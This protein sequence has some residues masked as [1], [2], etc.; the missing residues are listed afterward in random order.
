MLFQVE[1][2]W[3]EKSPDRALSRDY[4]CHELSENIGDDSQ[5]DDRDIN[6]LRFEVEDFLKDSSK[7]RE[8]DTYE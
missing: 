5:K 3:V 2:A 8:A 7:D 6:G 4:Q 1:W